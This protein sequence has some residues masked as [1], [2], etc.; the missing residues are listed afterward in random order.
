MKVDVEGAELEVLQGAHR[1]IAEFHPAIFAEIHGTQLH[2]DRRA[3][4][5]K[6]GYH[7]EEAYGQ[8]IGTPRRKSVSAS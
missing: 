8:V 7:V 3:F 4:L 1:V 6:E 5:L 2:A